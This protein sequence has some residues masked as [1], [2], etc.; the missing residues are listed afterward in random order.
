MLVCASFAQTIVKAGSFALLLFLYGVA[1]ADG[2]VCVVA[3]DDGC[4]EGVLLQIGT[5]NDFLRKG[6]GCEFCTCTR[7]ACPRQIVASTKIAGT[8]GTVATEEAA[9]KAAPATVVRADAIAGMCDAASC[10]CIDTAGI[11]LAY[12]GEKSLS[13]RSTTWFNAKPVFVPA[14]LNALLKTLSK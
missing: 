8:T 7:G 14:P 3:I 11:G 9:F 10:P 2:G 13:T 12:T 5:E 4:I 6:T 1:V